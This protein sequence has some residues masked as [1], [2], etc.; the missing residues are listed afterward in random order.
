MG[1]PQT[2]QE[3]AGTEVPLGS[4][5][6]GQLPCPSTALLCLGSRAYPWTKPL[7]GKGLCT[8]TLSCLHL[9]AWSP[10]NDTNIPTTIPAV[11]STPRSLGTTFYQVSSFR[12]ASG[13]RNGLPVGPV[14]AEGAGVGG[15]PSSTPNAMW[16]EKAIQGL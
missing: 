12:V 2:E 6:G 13:Q 3:I 9:K 16:G 4:I 1:C 5:P 14:R 11:H 15:G 7:H 10:T 8:H